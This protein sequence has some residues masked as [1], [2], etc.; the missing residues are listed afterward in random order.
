MIS[1]S[2]RFQHIS[3][4]TARLFRA[5]EIEVKEKYHGGRTY[6]FALSSY[7][8]LYVELKSTPGL[9]RYQLRQALKRGRYSEYTQAILAWK[10]WGD[11]ADTQHLPF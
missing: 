5:C 2:D 4:M 11:K 8:D 3:P 7:V 6:S 9:S 1:P 10:E